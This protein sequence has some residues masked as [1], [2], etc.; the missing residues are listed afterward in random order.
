MADSGVSRHR[1]AI[2]RKLGSEWLVSGACSS[3]AMIFSMEYKGYSLG[4]LPD[5]H[6][7]DKKL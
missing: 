3:T 5:A 4:W 7:V 6:G 1:S 2:T